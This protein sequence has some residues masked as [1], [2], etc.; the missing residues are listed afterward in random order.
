MNVIK[1]PEQ[2]E[3]MRISGAL[4]AR[5]LDMLVSCAKPGHSGKELDAIAEEFIRDHN[6]IP[7][8]KNY[9]QPDN[10]FPATIC[11]SR[12]SVV[13]HGIPTETDIIEEGDVVTIDCGLSL[14]GWFADAARLFGVGELEQ[15]DI[16]IIRASEAAI[17]AGIDACVIGNKLGDVGRAIH[18][19]AVSSP[20]Y[21]I[22]EF[23]GH[24]IG[25]RMH[26]EPQVPNAGVKGKGL[27]LQ[28]GMV[29][30]LEPMLK[31]TKTPLGLLPDKWTIATRD[32]TRATHIEHMVLVTENR[33]E[34]L[35]A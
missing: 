22:L 25:Q 32:G 24:A 1:T 12:N 11:F 34:I 33:P 10:P 27:E 20:F 6:G 23:C 21:N 30:C 28:S 15:D 7:A 17:N 18:L 16:D 29:F 31:K 26:E 3:K 2:V 5:C 19:S 8:F 14:N 9:G 13:V 35:T 4:L